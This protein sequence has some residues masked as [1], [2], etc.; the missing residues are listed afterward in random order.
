MQIGETLISLHDNEDPIF[1]IDLVPFLATS[2]DE[3]RKLWE[4]TKPLVERKLST[5]AHTRVLSP[6]CFRVRKMGRSPRSAQ[7][8]RMIA[9]MLRF[10]ACL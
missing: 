2:Y 6:N 8:A 7:D 4:A 10:L 9:E 3:A 5:R 1:G